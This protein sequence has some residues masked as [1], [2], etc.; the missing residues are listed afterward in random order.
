MVTY[1]ILDKNHEIIAN[2]TGV[3]CFSELT[4]TPH[5]K[6]AFVKYTINT[7][8]SKTDIEQF[9][10]YLKSIP[11]SR[12][13]FYWENIKEMI[14]PLKNNGL[15]VF[16]ILNLLRLMEEYPKVVKSIIS[17]KSNCRTS[18]KKYDEICRIFYSHI[19]WDSSHFISRKPDK[20]KIFFF[21]DKYWK[22][23]KPCNETGAIA[24][25]FETFKYV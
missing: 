5:K 1:A 25:L 12:H 7:N 3:A 10:H 19:T 13:L 23:K 20:N 18:N 4:T 14:V 16:T 8:L 6:G 21:N 9:L 22:V 24:K 11:N 2:F 15:K 17:N